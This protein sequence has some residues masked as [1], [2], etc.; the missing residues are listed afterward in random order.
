MIIGV[1]IRPGPFNLKL[2]S[3]S[4]PLTVANFF[5]KFLLHKNRRGGGELFLKNAQ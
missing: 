5:Q 2:Y 4:I 3:M 1:H